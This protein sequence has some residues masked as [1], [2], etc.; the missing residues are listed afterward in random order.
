MLKLLGWVVLLTTVFGL[1]Y[2]VGQ[3][4][5]GELQKTIADLTRNVRD[6]TL[7]FERTLRL[8]Q[9]LV[10]AK[11]G[12]IQAKS[13]LLDRNF[14][15]AADELGQAVEHL[16]KAG[17]AER[18]GGR[19]QKVRPLIIKVRE[20]QLDLSQGKALPRTKLDDIQKELDALLAQ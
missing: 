17:S 9:G 16:E 11:A 10:D 8:R 15:N 14:G 5:I 6:T 2:Y 18:D 13:E 1:G 4:P 19:P 12:V 7:G 20:A 3:H